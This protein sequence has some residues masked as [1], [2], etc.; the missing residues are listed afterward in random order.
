MSAYPFAGLQMP[1]S[2]PRRSFSLLI[3]VRGCESSDLHFATSASHWP[4]WLAAKSQASS[5]AIDCAPADGALKP[6]CNLPRETLATHLSS[7]KSS[8]LNKVSYILVTFRG[9]ALE[10]IGARAECKVQKSVTAEMRL[11]PT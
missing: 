9:S 6:L 8:D 3:A 2:A 10:K 1:D 7:W 5:E 11:G 4:W